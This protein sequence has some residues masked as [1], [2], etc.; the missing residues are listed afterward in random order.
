ML[1][2]VTLPPT[3]DAGMR[4][5]LDPG[6]G[7]ASVPVWTSVLG[8]TLTIAL[9]AGLWSFQSSL[10]HLLDTPHLYG[11]NWSVKSGAP[12]LPDLAGSLTPAFEQD[13]TVSALASGTVT[14]AELGLERV[15]VLGLQQNQGA[16]V[17]P[18]VLEGRL[19]KRPNE[20]MLGTSTLEKAG[21]HIGEIAVLRLGNIATGLRVVGR[22]VF[23]EFGDT[24]RLGN[25]VFLTYRG[26][27]EAAP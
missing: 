10:G 24:G 11:W 27:E 12:A 9:L 14:Q 2:R 4:F 25:G 19:P 26:V 6:R 18:T 3:A 20:T 8:V 17:A 21:L 16:T 5:A 7:S 15:D 23:P 1:D 22:G 13:P